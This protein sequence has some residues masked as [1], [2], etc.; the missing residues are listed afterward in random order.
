MARKTFDH[1]DPA[2]K[3]AII[4]AMVGMSPDGETGPTCDQWMAHKPSHLPGRDVVSRMFGGWKS[5]IAAAGLIYRRST[6]AQ[7]NKIRPLADLDR[8]LIEDGWT[9][10]DR[11]TPHHTPGD[12]R[13]D[14]WVVGEGCIDRGEKPYYD[15]A[16]Q[17]TIP[18]VVR[19]RQ[20]GDVYIVTVRTST[21]YELR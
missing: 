17:T 8:E 20:S 18:G 14:G 13:P 15:W 4:E 1:N 11:W 6:P 2:L 3:S 5:S 21:V 9:P 7:Y 10:S 12:E 19:L 16:H